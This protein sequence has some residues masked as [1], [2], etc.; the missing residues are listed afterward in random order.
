MILILPD[1][2]N[3]QY[4]VISLEP[5]KKP[6]GQNQQGPRELELLLSIHVDTHG[7]PSD[8]P[9]MGEPSALSY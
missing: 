7:L 9:K 2:D 1:V 3:I 8:I 4:K 5:I 6:Y